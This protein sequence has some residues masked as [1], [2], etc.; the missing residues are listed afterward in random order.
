MDN[1]GKLNKMI[2]ESNRIVFFGGAGVSTES[3]IPDFR[4][5]G[6]LYSKQ[7]EYPPEQILSRKFF[8]DHNEEF[9]KF[10]YDNIIGYNAIP[11]ITHQILAQSE[12]E[13]RL[14]G[15]ITQN[16]DGLHQMAGNTNVIELH[17]SIHRNNCINCGKFFDLKYI[18][19]NVPQPKCDSCGGI[20]KSSVVLYEENL[21]NKELCDSINLIKKSDLLIIGGTSLS[22]Y[23][24][25]GLIQYAGGKVAIINL[26]ETQYDAFADIVINQPL[27]EVF[28]KIRF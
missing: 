20:I 24:A 2:S 26:D 7:Y 3:G 14:E 12:K 6:G 17:G 27:G 8:Y 18:N 21:G 5:K 10:Y 28:A 25:S 13:G 22:V 15:I 1:I 4:G 11:S 19:E 23:P 16:I 9:Y